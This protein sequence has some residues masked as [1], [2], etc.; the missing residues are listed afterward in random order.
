MGMKMQQSHRHVCSRISLNITYE[1]W[2]IGSRDRHWEGPKVLSI[3]G[4][5]SER[6][7]EEVEGC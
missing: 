4:V 6:H 2:D 1:G 5:W 7:L 3:I